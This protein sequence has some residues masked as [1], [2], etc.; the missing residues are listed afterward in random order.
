MFRRD[1]QSLADII[2]CCLR[3]D[4]LETPLKQRRVVDAWGRV[5][6]KAVE[7]YTGEKFIRNQTLFVKITNPALRADLSMM[8]ERLVKNLNAEVGAQV[9]T[10]IKLF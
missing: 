3:A 9:I 8:R 5:V 4:G 6:G 10:D 1:V 7:K 2:A